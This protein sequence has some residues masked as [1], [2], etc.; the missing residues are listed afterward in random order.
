[1]ILRFSQILRHPGLVSRS[2]LRPGEKLETGGIPWRP[3]GPRNKSGVTTWVGHLS[4]AIMAV[5]APAEAKPSPSSSRNSST[6]P[7][8]QAHASTIVDL[9][10][11]QLA[12][13]DGVSPDGTRYPTWNPVLF[14]PAGQPLHLF[15]KVGPSPTQCGRGPEAAEI[16]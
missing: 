1:M 2:T 5:A 11:G 6:P 13:A 9:P 14:Q 10:N 12:V 16:G 7:Y 15:Y 8:P 3:R 4:F